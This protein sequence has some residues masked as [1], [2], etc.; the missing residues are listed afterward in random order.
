M[1]ETDKHEHL[2]DL[3]KGI[4][5]AMLITRAGG[6]LHARPMSVADLRADADAYFVTSLDSPKVAEIEA[7]PY[8]MITFQDGRQFAVISGNARVVRDRAV[9]DKLWSEAWKV[10]FPGGKDDPSL[11]LIKLE[12]Q[13]GEYWD[14]SGTKGLKYLFEG[15]R[16]VLQ[17][18]R[19]A[20]DETQHAKVAL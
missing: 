1:A 3:V 14:N 18:T 15:V 5:T 16:A 6:S 8:A 11:C 13:E 12:A 9:I 10:W 19:P 7:D 17:G 4:G 20:T 2:Y